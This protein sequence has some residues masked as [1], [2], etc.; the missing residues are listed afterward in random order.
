MV[1]GNCL[2]YEVSQITSGNQIFRAKAPSQVKFIK[3]GGLYLFREGEIVLDKALGKAIGRSHYLSPQNFTCLEGISLWLATESTPLSAFYKKKTKCIKR[4]KVEGFLFHTIALTLWNK[5]II[6]VISQ[7]VT[8]HSYCS[9]ETD[10]SGKCQSL[11]QFSFV[12]E[13]PAK[14]SVRTS[15]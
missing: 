11:C 8:F 13:Y 14:L 6:S 5:A 1:S 15:Y 7:P 9:A 2:G 4:N 3:A 12:I 10:F